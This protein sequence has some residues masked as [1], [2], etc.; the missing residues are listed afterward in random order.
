MSSSLPDLTEMINKLNDSVHKGVNENNRMISE[1]NEAAKNDWFSKLSSENKTKQTKYIKKYLYSKVITTPDKY[2]FIANL[3]GWNPESKGTTQSPSKNS[4]SKNSPGSSS[5]GSGSPEIKKFLYGRCTGMPEQ[6]TKWIDSS[7]VYVDPNSIKKPAE[8]PKGSCPCF[9]C[10][11]PAQQKQLIQINSEEY[12]KDIETCKSKV[13]QDS[14]EYI[15]E[16]K[17]WL[18]KI[19]NIRDEIIDNGPNTFETAY[20]SAIINSDNLQNKFITSKILNEESKNVQSNLENVGGMSIDKIR[21]AEINTYYAEKYR[22]QMKIVKLFI[23][24]GIILMI[25]IVIKKML[26]IPE[27][28]YTILMLTLFI[29]AVYYI[30]PAIYDYSRRDNIVFQQYDWSDYNPAVNEEDTSVNEQ[31]PAPEPEYVP[32]QEVKCKPCEK[33]E[34]VSD[35]VKRIAGIRQGE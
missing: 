24:F 6:I 15:N 1:C 29:Y 17:Q 33:D 18:E 26:Y 5:S 19:N 12:N 35:I 21:M 9:E 25:L 3:Y 22:L 20:K 4:P 34:A 14:D 7:G 16:G 8:K 31:T 10:L 32:T 30:I 23:F 2:N 28:I 13:T 27:I 11:T